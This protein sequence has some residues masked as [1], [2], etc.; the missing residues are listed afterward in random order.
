MHSGI[1]RTIRPLKGGTLGMPVNAY[2]L[3]PE[4][5]VCLGYMVR[6]D[7]K[8]EGSA[9]IWGNMGGTGGHP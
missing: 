1:L 7:L 4:F 8:K 9:V 2:L 5:Q 3:N 6:P